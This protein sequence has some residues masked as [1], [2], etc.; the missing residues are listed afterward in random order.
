M[1]GGGAVDISSMSLP[2][3][4]F[5]YMFRPLP[6]E[7]DGIPGFAAAFDNMVLLLLFVLGGRGLFKQRAVDALHNRAFLWFFSLSAWVVLAMTSANLGISL[8]QKWMFAPMLIFLLI[9]VAGRSRASATDTRVSAA[10]PRTA[11]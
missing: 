3:Q 2:M 6:F 9:S 5:T 7:T 11:S 8:R 1:E 10:V 4:M